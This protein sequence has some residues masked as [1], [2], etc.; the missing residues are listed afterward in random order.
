MTKFPI[1]PPRIGFSAPV[2][3]QEQL[4][5]MHRSMK[6][7]RLFQERLMAMLASPDDKHLIETSIRLE[8]G[9]EAVAVGAC[10]ALRKEDLIAPDFHPIAQILAKGGDLNRL[11]AEILGRNTGY[12]KGRTG[13]FHLSDY[14]AGILSNSGVMASHI[15]LA[16]GAALAS[17]VMNKD[18]VTLCFFGDA[19]VCEGEFYESMNMAAL[20][21]L[22]IVYICVNNG[23]GANLR[24]REH[25][26]SWNIADRGATFCVP[27]FIAD[28]N[29]PVAVYGTVSEAVE[30]AKRGEGPSLIEARCHDWHTVHNESPGENLFDREH[31]FKPKAATR[32]RTLPLLWTMNDPVENFQAKLLRTGMLTDQK[33]SAVETQLKA[34]IDEAV[35][36]AKRSPSPALEE[37]MNDIFAD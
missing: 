36:F 14:S 24:P 11:M 31:W 6:L 27:G 2:L 17:K 7:I 1:R 13:L 12:N 28:G 30:R 23:Y 26:A 33:V 16:T 10:F 35:E 25:T 9:E 21:D 3:S 29:D 15:P 32:N 18:E 20:W 19:A 8:R 22:P 37:A 5:E 4:I 34:I